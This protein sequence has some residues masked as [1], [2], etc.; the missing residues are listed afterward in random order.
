MQIVLAKLETDYVIEQEGRIDLGEMH[1]FREIK[2]P[3]ACIWVNNGNEEDKIKAEKFA[4]TEGYKVFTYINEKEPL[5][6]ARKDILKQ[7][8]NKNNGGN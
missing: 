4:I 3:I 2:K 7:G 6:R 5:K 8:Y 1:K